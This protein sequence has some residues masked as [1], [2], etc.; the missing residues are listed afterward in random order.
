MM[1]WRLQALVPLLALA[2]QACQTTAP[3]PEQAPASAQV[4]DVPFFPQDDYQCGPAALATVLGWSGLETS[5]EA[6]VDEVWLPERRGSLAME[7][8]AAARERGR[9]VYPLE[10]A[11][12][13]LAAVH[14]GQPVLVLQNLALPRW[15]RW[16]FAVVSGYRDQGARLVLNS[17][18][19]EAMTT[20]WNRFERTWA[21][22]ERQAW[23]VLP[24]GELPAPA[25]PLRLVRALH[26][27]ESTAGPDA[28]GPF[29]KQAAE[30]FPE[31]YP[32]RFGEGN[33]LWT[34]GE[35]ADALRAFRKA[36]LARPEAPEAWYNLVVGLGESG[37]TEL[38]RDMKAEARKKAGN[39]LPTLPEAPAETGGQCPLEDLPG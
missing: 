8:S 37:C 12:E 36:T 11:E 26:D 20:S 28:A 34:R 7:L 39:S 17:G 31:S 33:H 25:E 30:R 38:F 23:L 21:R 14:A 16:H 9:L 19:R 1:N 5:D 3:L 13:L 15:P 24:P 29:W 4:P 22:A 10:E 18:R 6:L 2:L 35:R 27:L 32:V